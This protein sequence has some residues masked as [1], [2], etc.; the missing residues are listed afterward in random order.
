MQVILECYNG[1]GEY[2]SAL[3]AGEIGR[4]LR[5]GHCGHG[6]MWFSGY[7]TR[8][9]NLRAG[10]NRRIRKRIRVRRCRC[11]RCRL[12]MSLLPGFCRPRLQFGP[13]TA[14]PVLMEM[15]RNHR[16]HPGAFRGPEEFGPSLRTVRRWMERLAA[17]ADIRSVDGEDQAVRERMRGALR[18]EDHGSLASLLFAAPASS[19]R[20]ESQ[21]HHYLVN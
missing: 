13:E 14:I 20:C 21:R 17:T 3:A 6:R 9:V 15:A 11:A 4:P 18:R 2:E 16:V 1:I 19:P 8:W 10:Q 12:T 5:C 7:Y